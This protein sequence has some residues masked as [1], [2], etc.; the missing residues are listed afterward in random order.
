MAYPCRRSPGPPIGTPTSRERRTIY[1]VTDG[2]YSDYQILEVFESKEH[3][4]AFAAEGQ[5]ESRLNHRTVEDYV[6][7]PADRP[8]I[9]VLRMTCSVDNSG[10]VVND[11]EH[12]EVVRGPFSEARPVS[13][14]ESYDR[15]YER[16]RLIVSGTDHERVRKVYSERKARLKAEADATGFRGR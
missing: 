2:A 10:R 6:M 11:Y 8:L 3:A 14:H 13:V 7:W 16:V 5:K 15:D 4:E 1:V 9:E 12:S